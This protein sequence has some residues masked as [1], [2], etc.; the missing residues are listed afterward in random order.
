MQTAR[1]RFTEDEY[2]A[3]ERA[4]DSRHELINGE[5]VAMAGGTPEHALVASNVSAALRNRLRGRGCMPLSADARI[6]VPAT[7]LYTYPDDS[8]FCGVL[9]RH[10]KDANT[11]LDPTLL[12]EVVSEGTEA[13]DR[14]AKFAHYRSI[15]SLRAYLIVSP[16]DRTLELFERNADGSWTISGPT[17]PGEAVSVRALG[18]E[19]PTDEV[20]EDLDLATGGG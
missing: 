20:F 8:V 1:A 19:V 2:L 5:I 7:G 6:Q 16:S 13:Y 17:G 14:G 3:L 12:V 10:P 11:L 9:E 4:A 18:I 15:V